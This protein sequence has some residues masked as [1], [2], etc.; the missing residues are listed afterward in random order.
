VINAHG[1]DVA[2]NDLPDIFNTPRQQPLADE[3]G[4]FKAAPG[5]LSTPEAIYQFLLAGNAYF[6]VRSTKTGTRYTFRVNKPQPNDTDKAY[7]GNQSTRYFVALLTGP[8]NTDDYT[9]LG[10]IQGNQFRLTRASKMTANS[11]PVLAFKWVFEHAVRH[12]LPPQCECWHEGRCG[13]CG[14]M[15]TVPESIERGIGPDCAGMMGL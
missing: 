5:R 14:R 12:Q 11:G 7:Y 8:E 10:M 4:P 15:L 3:Q 6:T 9:Y 1:V 13:R 2:D